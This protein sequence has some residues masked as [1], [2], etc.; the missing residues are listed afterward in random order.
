[1]IGELS[2]KITAKCP[3]DMKFA[4]ELHPTESEHKWRFTALSELLVRI[5]EQ[6]LSCM[7]SRLVG[8][9]GA[10]P[11]ALISMHDGVMVSPHLIRPNGQLA[12]RERQLGTP[13][14]IDQEVLRDICGYTREQLGVFIKLTV[15]DGH[16][17][18]ELTCGEEW[19]VKECCAPITI[20]KAE[21]LTKFTSP[22]AS[23]LKP[24]N[25]ILTRTP[26]P[27]KPYRCLSVHQDTVKLHHNAWPVNPETV[28]ISLP[29]AISLREIYLG[30]DYTF[31]QDCT[32]LISFYLKLPKK[33]IASGLAMTHP[34]IH[35]LARDIFQMETCLTTPLNIPLGTDSIPRNAIAPSHLYPLPPQFSNLYGSPCPNSWNTAPFTYTANL[36]VCL[37]SQA[38]PDLKAHY[39]YELE[40]LAH[41]KKR[42]L[43]I[44]ETTNDSLNFTRHSRTFN[45]IKVEHIFTIPPKSILWTNY[46]G[47]AIC[48]PDHKK[49]PLSWKSEPMINGPRLDGRWDLPRNDTVPL[50]QHS[51]VFLLYRH[52]TDRFAMT[53]Q[54]IHQVSDT[55]SRITSP[56][57]PGAS[58]ESRIATL[59]HAGARRSLALRHQ[60]PSP[61]STIDIYRSLRL[62][63]FLPGNL[64]PTTHTP[65]HYRLFG[66]LISLRKYES[67]P[68]GTIPPQLLDY[69][70]IKDREKGIA[71]RNVF[72]TISA[73]VCP[74]IA[75]E[76]TRRR[77][78][79][80]IMSLLGS[81]TDHLDPGSTIAR[82]PLQCPKCSKLTP[83][84]WKISPSTHPEPAQMIILEIAKHISSNESL[85]AGASDSYKEKCRS[86]LITFFSTKDTFLCYMCATPVIIEIRK[87]LQAHAVSTNHVIDDIKNIA[88][89]KQPTLEFIEN[90][91]EIDHPWGS[92]Q[93]REIIGSFVKG[94]K[95]DD[96]SRQI[97]ALA[98]ST[99]PDHPQELRYFIGPPINAPDLE[100]GPSEAYEEWP[101]ESTQEHNRYYNDFTGITMDTPET[102]V[103]KRPQ[104][105]YRQLP[106]LLKPPEEGHMVHRWKKRPLKKAKPPPPPLPPTR[107]GGDPGPTS[108]LLHET[109]IEELTARIYEDNE[110]HWLLALVIRRC[111]TREDQRY[112]ELKAWLKEITNSDELDLLAGFLE[113]LYDDV[114]R[115]FKQTVITPEALKRT[116][117]TGFLRAMMGEPLTKPHAW[118]DISTELSRVLASRDEAD[119]EKLTAAYFKLKQIAYNTKRYVTRTKRY[120]RGAEILASHVMYSTTPTKESFILDYDPKNSLERLR[121][122]PRTPHNDSEIDK[123]T[124]WTDANAILIENARNYYPHIDPLYVQ[125]DGNCLY[126]AHNAAQYALGPEHHLENTFSHKDLRILACT[127]AR[128]YIDDLDPDTYD[129]E[130]ITEI[131]QAIMDGSDVTNELI[132]IALAS[133][134]NGVIIMIDEAGPPKR[135]NPNPDMQALLAPALTDPKSE[136][137]TLLNRTRT[138]NGNLTR[139]ECAPNRENMRCNRNMA[140]T[141]WMNYP[142]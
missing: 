101:I 57:E 41:G 69:I 138:L 71:K 19:P 136:T 21:N 43:L 78:I 83:A 51:I 97:M 113:A 64:P 84:L 89:N 131:D 9:W 77:M 100:S 94:P 75:L 44:L 11:K 116:P 85:P 76:T 31:A 24:P 102:P 38:D 112:R 80:R 23:F 135:Y 79:L 42:G 13:P 108:P 74:I 124:R 37:H 132:L 117:N 20:R 122:L 66:P 1:M 8:H 105:T 33:S 4:R 36:T 26:D 2:V 133:I 109:T 25:L 46:K 134:R 127:L 15:K 55:L 82:A 142:R 3:D 91:P 60:T 86:Q 103:P 125:P 129:Q 28:S 54:Q 29:R 96:P 126:H 98:P 73:L 111:L 5:E 22:D 18:T 95:P 110:P 16:D 56:V 61:E 35:E 34:E 128:K 118:E 47:N 88:Q 58:I 6:K 14:T 40:H 90:P 30:I 99:K 10:N 115:V 62:I 52:K 70:T 114:K 48:S 39:K 7:I 107:G 32:S 45:D 81:P 92:P 17:A 63:H 67:I 68:D 120:A 139:P 49:N 87:G 119:T 59:H 72:S 50:N 12:K 65:E 123:F 106:N 53:T 140:T 141:I 27:T 104:K 137:I 130:S 121:R 93:E